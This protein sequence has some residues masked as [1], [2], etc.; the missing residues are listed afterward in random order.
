MTS[1]QAEIMRLRAEVARLQAERDQH[2]NTSREQTRQWEQT[3]RPRLLNMMFLPENQED[4]RNET[5]SRILDKIQR[6]ILDNHGN[7]GTGNSG[8]GTTQQSGSGLV[9]PIS[10]STLTIPGYGERYNPEDFLV[11]SNLNELHE[12][13]M[14]IMSRNLDETFNR[15]ISEI[16]KDFRTLLE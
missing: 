14:D 3:D 7:T 8:T 16:I 13:K 12:R 10:R 9:A 6:D 2:R 11:D 4:V 1:V 15:P 5:L